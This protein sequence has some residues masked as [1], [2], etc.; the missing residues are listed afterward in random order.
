MSITCLK[1]E[2]ERNILLRANYKHKLNKLLRAK[3]RH[4]LN[5]LRFV[6]SNRIPR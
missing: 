4:K 5:K 2:D 3:Y 1:Y 6:L